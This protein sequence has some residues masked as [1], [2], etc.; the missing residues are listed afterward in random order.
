MNNHAFSEIIHLLLEG[1]IIDNVRFKELYD[2]LQDHENLNKINE[3]LERIE[4]CCQL[5][6]DSSGYYCIYSNIRQKN[7]RQTIQKQ[8][9]DLVGKLEP[10]IDWMR[11]CRTTQ[12][13][14]KTITYGDIIQQGTLLTAIEQS[15]HLQTQLK[16][17]VHKLGRSSLTSASKDQLE[18]VLRFLVAERYLHP[19]GGD[20]GS[21]YVATAKWSLLYEQ[22]EYIASCE[23][24]KHE[25][26]YQQVNLL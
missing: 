16:D 13:Q 15:Q 18:S 20:T 12:E 3:Y 14:N 4:R 2:R 22:L 11:L 25:Q 8:F 9:N 17:I 1:E 10:I 5:T 21:V 7:A 26:Q 6:K 19:T 23:H 24:I